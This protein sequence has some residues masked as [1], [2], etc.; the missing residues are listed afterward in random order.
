MAIDRLNL[1]Y[2]PRRL[3][4][5]SIALLVFALF[6]GG[7]LLGRGRTDLSIWFFGIGS[8]L[9][10]VGLCLPV[11][12]YPLYVALAVATYPLGY[13]FSYILLGI[14]FYA[15]ITPIGLVM[16]I[17]GKDPLKTP[18]DSNTTFWKSLNKSAPPDQYFKQY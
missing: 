6:W 13:V 17:I 5:F 1:R 10:L 9:T 15:I 8:I 7:V 12:V 3:R 14:V 11:I 16:K 4:Q 2:D 18:S